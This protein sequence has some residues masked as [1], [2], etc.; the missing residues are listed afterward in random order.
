MK[1]N[2]EYTFGL[3]WKEELVAT[4]PG[5]G[6]VI[7]A[8]MGVLSVD[9][10]TEATWERFCPEWARGRWAEVRDAIEKWGAQQNIP[11]YIEG[12]AWIEFC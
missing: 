12:A 11:I 1:I 5:G 7:G 6:F 2:A 3:R 10:P 8:P 9:F 4:I